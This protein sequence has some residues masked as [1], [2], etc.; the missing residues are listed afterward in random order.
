MIIQ[1]VLRRQVL[2]E[3]MVRTD[4]QLSNR[5]TLDILEK[6]SNNTYTIT[7]YQYLSPSYL[8]E[9]PDN[10]TMSGILHSR[11]IE[12][13]HPEYA[14]HY[15]EEYLSALLSII[16]DQNSSVFILKNLCED[17]QVFIRSRKQRK[18]SVKPDCNEP[19]HLFID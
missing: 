12:V 4:Y 14:T 10:I 5:V 16:P 13:V 17:I 8:I 11:V 1:K 6:I 15:L 2:K 9:K 19:S 18:K 7:G 3:G